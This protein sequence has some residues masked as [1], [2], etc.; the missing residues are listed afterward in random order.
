MLFPVRVLN[1]WG[2]S[3]ELL[4]LLAIS[5][6]TREKAANVQEARRNEETASE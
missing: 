3:L 4:G 6:F 5:A 2:V 1:W